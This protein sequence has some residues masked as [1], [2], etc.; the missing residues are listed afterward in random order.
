MVVRNRKYESSEKRAR[1][2]DVQRQVRRAATDVAGKSGADTRTSCRR[3]RCKSNH[4]LQL[5]VWTD[6]TQS[7]SVPIACRTIWSQIFENSTTRKLAF[8]KT[9]NPPIDFYF[10]FCKITPVVSVGVSESHFSAPAA[11]TETTTTADGRGRIFYVN[12]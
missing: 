12:H 3:Y 6:G 7:G 4:D 9:Q 1:H 2:F 5:G 11:P 8:Y 10:V